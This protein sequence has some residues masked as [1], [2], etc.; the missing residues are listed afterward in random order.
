[1]SET[2]IIHEPAPTTHW[3]T[4]HKSKM[5]L[6]GSQNLNEGE[7]LVMTIK[8]FDPEGEIKNHRGATEVK[9]FVYFEETE[10]PMIINIVNSKILEGLYG[11]DYSKWIGKQVQIFVGKDR[12][13]N[14]GGQVD[15]LR[16]RSFI[17][18]ADVDTTEW[19]KAIAECNSVDDITKVWK[20]IPKHLHGKVQPFATAKKEELAE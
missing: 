16:F 18:E 14:G 17:P 10:T 11:S 20:K 9:P 2:K 13:P 15:C 3:K 7:E 12:N 1:M 19:E 8:R 5:L 6:L 4:L